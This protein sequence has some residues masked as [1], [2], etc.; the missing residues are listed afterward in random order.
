MH[1]SDSA[2]RS[3]A[4]NDLEEKAEKLVSQNWKVIEGLVS[5]LL[6]KAYTPM[7]PIEIVEGWSRDKK[8]I[9]K[10]MRGSEV[11]EFF[12]TFQIGASIRRE[13][14]EVGRRDEIR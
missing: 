3:A 9:E 8:G 4:Q 14:V 11:V 6:G 1:P 7:P 2:A 12:R 5:A 13:E 10:W